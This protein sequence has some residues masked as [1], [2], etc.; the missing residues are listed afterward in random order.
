VFIHVIRQRVAISHCECRAATP[1]G[2]AQVVCRHAAALA[3]VLSTTR[4]S[5]A[6]SESPESKIPKRV[7]A[8]VS[9]TY[10]TS[11]KPLVDERGLPLHM[12]SLIDK[13]RRQLDM[14]NG[15][16]RRQKRLSGPNAPKRKRLT[17]F[18]FYMAKMR[19]E[20]RSENPQLKATEV[21]KRIGEM[22]KALPCEE[23]RHYAEE[24][25]EEAERIDEEWAAYEQ[26]EEYRQLAAEQQLRLMSAKANCTAERTGGSIAK[27]SKEST[28]RQQQKEEF[29]RLGDDDDEPT[30]RGPSFDSESRA[31]SGVNTV[32]VGRV[33]FGETSDATAETLGD[34]RISLLHKTSET[35]CDLE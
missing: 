5:D 18:F 16:E 24:C 10:S 22:W 31:R 28:R 13:A 4:R 9:S 30:K 6:L 32:T 23:K 27:Q 8:A 33:R 2:F 3:Y 1:C 12:V 25:Q 15:T 14:E 34:S 11:E 29:E 21:A 19:D 35:H 20:V 7:P 26:T 17:P